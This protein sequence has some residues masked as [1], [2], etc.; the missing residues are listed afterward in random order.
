MAR[1]VLRSVDGGP[2]YLR[3]AKTT[4]TCKFE[5]GTQFV[6]TSHWREDTATVVG[7]DVQV[8]SGGQGEALLDI[9]DSGG[10]PGWIMTPW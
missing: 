2:E 3:P 5:P 10:N 9:H 6:M 7:I 1:F 8:F 4:P